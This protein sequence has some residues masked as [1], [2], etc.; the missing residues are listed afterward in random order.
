MKQ[1]M[2]ESMMSGF[3]GKALIAGVTLSCCFFGHQIRP[4][5]N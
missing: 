1:S 4:A 5:K 3:W 2:K